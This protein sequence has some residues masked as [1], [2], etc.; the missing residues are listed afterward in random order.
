[1]LCAMNDNNQ[2][3]IQYIDSSSALITFCDAIKN[4]PWLAIDTEFVREKTYYPQLC[5][6]Q[7]SNDEQLACIDPIALGNIDPLLDV[8]YDK[9][10]TKVFHAASQD[11]EI[12]ANLRNALPMPLFDTQIA[13]ALLGHGNQ[14]SYAALVQEYFDIEL[15]KSHSRTDWSRRPL[16][17]VQIRYAADDVLYLG[18]LYGLLQTQ[19]AKMDRQRWLDDDFTQLANIERYQINP[20]T[21]WQQVKGLDKLA[22]NKLVYVQALA[23]WREQYAQKINKP[24]RWIIKDDILLAMAEGP[25]KNNA[26]LDAAGLTSKTRDRYG[27]DW[28]KL[29]NEA[30]NIPT[31]QH[32]IRQRF[33]RLTNQQRKLGKQLMQALQ[34][35]GEAQQ[36]DPGL[37]ATRKIVNQ[38]VAGERDV[39]VLKGW[40]NDLAGQKLLTI[41]D[42]NSEV[43]PE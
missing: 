34:T 38:L 3:E 18:K 6:I 41:I 31:E 25:A 35:I 1:M 4:S 36:I 40:R 28:L 19:L 11:L 42:K 16:S 9:N 2:P 27:K 10:I 32:P 33:E 39:P 20:E 13:A 22:G 14:I 43:S 37:I 23:R 26:D 15:D 12:F 29:L 7:V 30:D 8:L 24:K 21:S 5:L 17:E